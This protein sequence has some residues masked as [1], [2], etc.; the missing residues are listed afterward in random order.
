[1]IAY[2]L[3]EL[4]QSTWTLGKLNIVQVLV[5]SLGAGATDHVADVFLGKFI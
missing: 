2:G 1:L 4:I 5:F 3:Q